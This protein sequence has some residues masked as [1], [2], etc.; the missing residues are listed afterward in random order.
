MVFEIVLGLL[1]IV[2]VWINYNLYHNLDNFESNYIELEESK[3]QDET[4]ILELRKK[5]LAYRSQIRR[6][7]NIGAFEADD[8]VGYFFKE[9][10]RMIEEISTYFDITDDV[11]VSATNEFSTI[12][13]GKYGEE[14]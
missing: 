1:L 9:L 11:K 7:D 2:S 14:N 12:T 6:M 8:E 3:L 5:V 10:N 4:F 13:R